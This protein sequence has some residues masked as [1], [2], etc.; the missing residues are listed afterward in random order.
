MI[1]KHLAIPV[2]LDKAI[3]AM[4]DSKGITYTEMVRRVLEQGVASMQP[5]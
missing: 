5:F 3:R 1:K 4:A 2:P